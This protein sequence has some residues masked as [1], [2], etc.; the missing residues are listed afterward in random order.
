[1]P[2]RNIFLETILHETADAILFLDPDDIIRYWNRGAMELYGFQAEEVLGKHYSF[3]IPEPLREREVEEIHKFMKE[4][5]YV[6]SYE[7]QRIRKDGRKIYVELTRT[8]VRDSEGR[9]LGTSAV[10]RD[11]TQKRE[12]QEQLANMQRL[13]AMTRVAG[14]VAHE[15]RTPLGVFALKCDLLEEEI[16]TLMANLQG[17]QH[18]EAK[19]E[20]RRFMSPDY[21]ITS[22]GRLEEVIREVEERL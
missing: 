12:M 20:I 21:A 10:V 6:R 3:L 11:I 13:S 8:I 2:T 14:K 18:D 15:M 17:L 7:T 19:E 22:L 16:E 5:G 4:K 9:V 1:L